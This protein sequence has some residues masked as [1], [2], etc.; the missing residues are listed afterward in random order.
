MSETQ[1]Q[2]GNGA[3]KR[4]VT[5]VENKCTCEYCEKHQEDTILEKAKEDAWCAYE[6][7]EGELYSNTFKD[8]FELGAKWQ[9]ERM[10]SEKDISEALEILIQHQRWR[11]SLTNDMPYTPSQL[12]EALDVVIAELQK[13]L[14]N[15]YG[16]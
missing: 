16:K 3:E 8:G 1:E 5:A 2:Y 12:T 13:K 9:K 7:T 10:Y 14:T 4:P 15:T 11:Q 6:Y